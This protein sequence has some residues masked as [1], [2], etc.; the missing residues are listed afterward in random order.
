MQIASERRS[1]RTGLAAGLLTL[2]L[3]STQG[4]CRCQ[5]TRPVAATDAGAPPAATAWLSGSVVDRKDR[6]VPE[7]RVL[8]FPLAGDGGAPA[9]PAPFET[10]TDLS[11]Q[12]RFA[13]LPPG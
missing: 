7:A 9:A 4:G 13:R 11:G 12:F 3:F 8:A 1:S 2:L 5:R 6:P 10:A